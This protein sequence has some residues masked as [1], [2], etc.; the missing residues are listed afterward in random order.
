[1]SGI[2]LL[3]AIIAVLGLAALMGC[4]QPPPATEQAQP[5]PMQANGDGNGSPMVNRIAYIDNSGDLRLVN[6]DGTGDERLTGDVRAGLLAQALERGDSYSWPT[7]NPDGAKLAASRVSISGQDA[8]LS[9]QLFDLD[10]GGMIS[11]FENDVPAPVADGA[12]HYI[13]W[14]PDGRY[15]TVLAPTRE[16]LAL[17]VRDYQGS[18]D[19]SA[20]A[21]GAP[22]YYHWGRDSGVIAVH[23]GDRLMVSEPSPDGAQA[24]LH[25][26]AVGFRAPALSPDGTHLAYAATEGEVH[27]VFVRAIGPPSSF[28]PSPSGGGLGWGQP[29]LLMETRVLAAFAWA[30]DG[31]TLAV[32]EQAG[33]GSPLFNRLSL[34][35][36]D[37]SSSSVL[38]EEAHLAFFWSPSGDR[39][40]WVG[41]DPAT[42]E[43]ELSLSSVIG[44]E[45]RRLFRFSPT[46]EFFT[47]LSFFD[48]YAYSHS[49]WSP[50]G[51]AL[52]VAG[53]EGPE[54]GR[55][56]GSGPSGGQIYVVDAG[57]GESRRIASGRTAVWSWN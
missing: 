14:S 19:A 55:R 44:G 49:L 6:P 57:T 45:S 27:G 29:R 33:P 20:L 38:V 53:N 39:I 21:V 32:S 51:S 22:L 4:G 25:S 12:A 36:A 11:A 16:G 48:Q 37:G 13:Y 31:S 2:R 43:M 15:L 10:T 23:S 8:G 52:V 56:N 26:D 34:W 47:Y 1:M 54:S 24:Q 3:I 17:F 40:A 41:V 35:A 50:D 5:S 9:V 42:R 7:W 30:P 18:D 28:S 46:G